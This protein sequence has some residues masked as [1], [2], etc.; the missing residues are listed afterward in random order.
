MRKLVAVAT[1]ALF[2]I[3]AAATRAPTQ[4]NEPTVDDSLD[5]LARRAVSRDSSVAADARAQLRQAGQPGLDALFDTFPQCAA[6]STGVTLPTDAKAQRWRAAV[7]AVSRQRDAAFSRLYWYT[8]LDR[9]LEAAEQTGRR[10]LSLRLLGNLDE[11]RSCANSR[12]FR[13]VLYADPVV[14]EELR[15]SYILHWQSVRPVPTIRIDLGDG[16]VI[17]RTITG[18]SIHYVL[19]DAGRILDA[20]PGL[21]SAD[22]FLAALRGSAPPGDRE[23]IAVNPIAAESVERLRPPQGAGNLPAAE[24][25]ALAFSKA[26]IEMPMVR[27]LADGTV[28]VIEP[29][30]SAGATISSAS[31]RLMWQKRYGA[32]ADPGNAQQRVHMQ[33]VVDDFARLLA[34]DTRLNQFTLRPRARRMLATLND[35]TDLRTFN[36]RIYADLFMTPL[37]DPWMGLVPENAY[38]ALEDEGLSRPAQTAPSKR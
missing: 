36:Q 30:A 1:V 13:T 20:I 15:D 10:V 14:A 27:E 2:I 26:R 19:D 18:N 23:Q 24:A 35:P 37:D 12:Y 31:R 4:A 3:L 7:E 25:G 32:D 16:H 21:W 38:A 34:S 9:A 5:E 22:A 29:T 8:D 11:E 6:R 17:N 33:R 28:E